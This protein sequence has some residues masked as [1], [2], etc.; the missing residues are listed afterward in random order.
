MKKY[1]GSLSFFSLTF[2]H[3]YVRRKV[4]PTWE[5]HLTC[6]HFT[7]LVVVWW[8]DIW[9]CWAVVEDEC[10]AEANWR[11]DSMTANNATDPTMLTLITQLF[12]IWMKSDSLWLLLHR[13]TWRNVIA[14]D[15]KPSSFWDK[16]NIVKWK[17]NEIRKYL[18][19]K[20]NISRR[21]K[22]FAVFSSPRCKRLYFLRWRCR[23][24][25]SHTDVEWRDESTEEEGEKLSN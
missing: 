14:V 21:R 12:V 6:L 20:E 5:F 22:V 19:R 13:S 4:F 3:M 2:L 18:K 17:F 24:V 25:L 23:W 1:F 11:C 9:C 16:M 10:H 7:F 15:R 8:A